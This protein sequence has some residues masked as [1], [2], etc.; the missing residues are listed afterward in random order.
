MIDGADGLKQIEAP[1]PRHLL[2]QQHDAIGLP[3]QQDQRIVTVRAG[4]HGKAL[5]LEKQD[6][7]GEALDLIVDPEDALWDGACWKLKA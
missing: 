3:L 7:R 2:V 5:L 6:M 1:P 4:L